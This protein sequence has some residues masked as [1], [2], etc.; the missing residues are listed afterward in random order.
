MSKKNLKCS[1][2]GCSSPQDATY[3]KFPKASSM[4]LE[5]WLKACRR[6]DVLDVEKSKIC[7]EHFTTSDFERDV[8]HELLNLPPRKLL[9]PNAVPTQGLLP[10]VPAD[11]TDEKL[12]P[13]IDQQSS[14]Q[15]QVNTSV[16]LSRRK[17]KVTH[18]GK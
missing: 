3:F 13:T 16:S 11:S 18:K 14:S 17:M 9:K 15:S 7:S 1:V 5:N 8:R 6:K 12:A 2:S 10:E 4:L